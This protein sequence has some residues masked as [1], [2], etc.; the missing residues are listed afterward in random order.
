M[1]VGPLDLRTVCLDEA[2]R[3]WREE[4]R[5]RYGAEWRKLRGRKHPG[6]EQAEKSSGEEDRTLQIP[7]TRDSEIFGV[8]TV[9]PS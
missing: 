7:F 5:R 4:T 9:S 6:E 1:R 2:P 3:L 8:G